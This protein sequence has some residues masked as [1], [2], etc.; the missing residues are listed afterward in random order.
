R[1]QWVL[2]GPGR[3]PQTAPRLVGSNKGRRRCGLRPRAGRAGG[4]PRFG[5]LRPE[6]LAAP[7]TVYIEQFSAH[8]LERDA[9]DLYAPPDGYLA[10]DGIFHKERQSPDDVPV[11]E[12]TLR[13]EDGVYPLP[14]LARQANGQPWEDD[15]ARPL[16]P[17][18]LSRQPFYPD[19]SRLFEEIDRLGI[20]DSGLSNLLSCKAD[21][22]FWRAAPSGGYT[23]GLSAAERTDVG[24]REI[25]PEVMGE[26]FF[27][28]RPF[29]LRREPPMST[30][31]RL[32]NVVQRAMASGQYAGGIWLEG[33]PNVE[34][35]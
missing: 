12:I 35:T 31:A 15:S 9:A 32:T 11:Y 4:P 6:R 8:P 25:P 29:H 33:S 27:P 28:Y 19:A 22:D 2:R 10:P 17:P 5:V 23:K 26:D 20:G 18:E 3:T 14:Y 1:G 13:P 16:A 30:L 24:E 21:F 7:V 34:E